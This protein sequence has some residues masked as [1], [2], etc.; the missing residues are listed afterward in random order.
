MVL[1]LCGNFETI[2]LEH[3][4]GKV[5]EHAKAFCSFEMGK[6]TIVLKAFHCLWFTKEDH[7]VKAKKY[8]QSL[9]LKFVKKVPFP[10]HNEIFP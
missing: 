5:M 4:S 2:S 3:C 6:I 9:L 1:K 10:V 7:R 8:T